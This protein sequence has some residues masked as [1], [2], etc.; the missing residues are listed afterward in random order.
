MDT[1]VEEVDDPNPDR[2]RLAMASQK[3]QHC[4]KPHFSRGRACLWGIQQRRLAWIHRRLRLTTPSPPPWRSPS[5]SAPTGFDLSDFLN[6]ET[7]S[8]GKGFPR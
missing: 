7:R 8:R 5:D 1:K 4:S 6:Q 3:L 2:L